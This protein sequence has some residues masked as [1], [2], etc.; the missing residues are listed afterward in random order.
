MWLLLVLPEQTAG[1]VLAEP[2]LRWLRVAG[3]R[4]LLRLDSRALLSPP[5]PSAE[6]QPSAVQ[7]PS[8]VQQPSAVQRPRLV[9][10]LLQW[11]PL[12]VVQLP[13]ALQQ[14]PQ[15]DALLQSG[16]QQRQV[17]LLF[18]EWP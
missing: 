8:A 9:Q 10:M 13:Q 17:A 11:L 4:Q 16:A 2:V 15:R 1:L 12:Q 6:L 18:K 5:Q 3:P 14:P 7:R